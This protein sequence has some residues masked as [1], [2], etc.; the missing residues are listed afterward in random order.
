MYCRDQNQLF[1]PQPAPTPPPHRRA[2][3][4]VWQTKANQNSVLS[5]SGI[6]GN[7]SSPPELIGIAGGRQIQSVRINQERIY[8]M[9]Q[10]T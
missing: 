2:D 1:P 6:P 5:S 4:Q 9:P 10:G 3:S 7:S 8:V